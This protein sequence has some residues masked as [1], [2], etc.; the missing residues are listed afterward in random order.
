MFA[1]Q[2][3]TSALNGALP[4]LVTSGSILVI[5]G[6]LIGFISHREH[7]FRHRLV[8]GRGTIISLLLVLFVLPQ[9]LV[10]G[11]RLIS[12]TTVKGRSFA[13]IRFLTRTSSR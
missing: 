11:D 12:R 8:L 9:M 3:Y 4:T 1:P 6:L 10:W 2:V 5:A 7:N 13:C